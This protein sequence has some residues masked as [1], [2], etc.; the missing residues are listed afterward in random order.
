MKTLVEEYA[1]SIVAVVVF[2]ALILMV[3]PVAMRVEKVLNTEGEIKKTQ[4]DNATY[5]ANTSQLKDVRSVIVDERVI[6]DSVMINYSKV[7]DQYKDDIL[8][9]SPSL[10]FI[11]PI[12]FADYTLSATPWHY[13]ESFGGDVHLGADYAA[14]SGKSVYAPANGIIVASGDG[15]GVGFLGDK[16]KGRGENLVSA[17]GNQIWFM[18]SVNGKVYVFVFFHLLD[19]TVIHT[20]PVLQGDKIAE[21]GSSGNSTGPHTHIEMFY[22][23][24][25]DFSDIESTYMRADHSTSYGC[26]WGEYALNHICDS[27]TSMVNGTTCRINP[28]D[29]LPQS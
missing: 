15:C 16:C 14:L 27:S 22:I 26:T 28:V 3:A 12:N 19:G 8:A 2:V 18:T 17:G 20:G 4:V 25:G 9:L 10:S 29:F 7:A 6:N 1:L 11:S 5:Y 24:D 23:G 21:V 13:P